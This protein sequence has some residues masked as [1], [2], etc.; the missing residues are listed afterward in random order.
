MTYR[1]HIKN[2]QIL[3]D[4]PTSLPEGAAVDVQLVERHE[5]TDNSQPAIWNRLLKLAG[6]VEG[7]PSDAAENHDK[8]L[9]GKSGQS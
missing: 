5:P 7:L 9:S 3:L 8:Y 4:R 1:G 6:T 2:G